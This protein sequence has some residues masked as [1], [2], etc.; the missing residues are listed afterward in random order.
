MKNY[1][2]GIYFL[3][4]FLFSFAGYSQEQPGVS[5]KQT[6]KESIENL[7]IYPN[8]AT[9]GKI[10]ITS[11]LNK[12]KEV[13]IF[14]VLGKKIIS[15]SLLNKTLDVSSLSPGV[16]ILK[17]KEEAYSATRKLVIR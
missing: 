5:E 13:E 8:P 17:I 1:T 12:P 9:Q 4:V 15:T 10:Y 7:I 2:F 6:T 16:Y 11:K 3:L 14:D